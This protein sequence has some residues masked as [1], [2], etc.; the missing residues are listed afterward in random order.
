MYSNNQILTLPFLLK[1]EQAVHFYTDSTN[2]CA[3]CSISMI[4]FHWSFVK[5]AFLCYL[6]R[7]G[8]FRLSLIC[9]GTKFC[10]KMPMINNR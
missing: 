2:V 9:I 8:L 10:P 1:R 4:Y 7:L 3:D 5:E 6:I